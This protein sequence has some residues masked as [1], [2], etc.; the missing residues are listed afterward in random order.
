MKH[1]NR[2]RVTA[3]FFGGFA[4]QLSGFKASNMGRYTLAFLLTGLMSGHVLADEPPCLQLDDMS[5]LT[6]SLRESTQPKSCEN[7]ALISQPTAITTASS[8]AYTASLSASPDI[9]AST[10]SS[11]LDVT[12]PNTVWQVDVESKVATLGRD[13][14]GDSIDEASGNLSFRHVDVSLPGNSHLPVEFARTYRIDGIDYSGNILGGW[15]PDVPFITVRLDGAIGWVA[16]GGSGTDSHCFAN[17][18]VRMSGASNPDAHKKLAGGL[19]MSI[20]GQGMQPLVRPSN[21]TVNH[22]YYV[23]LPRIDAKTGTT[24]DNWKVICEGDIS[25]AP[26]Q[27]MTA[28]APN[29]DKYIFDVFVKRYAGMETHTTS[30]TRGGG[31]EQLEVNQAFHY[32]L[33]ASKIIDVSGNEVSY[34]YDGGG[35]LTKISANDGR[36]ID[37]SYKG[38]LFTEVPNSSTDLFSVD[39]ES[40][41]KSISSVTTNGRTWTYHYAT[42]DDDNYHTSVQLNLRSVTLPNGK[43]WTFN[44]PLQNNRATEYYNSY[45]C[46][47]ADKPDVDGYTGSWL[48]RLPSE[49]FVRHP[50]GAKINFEFDLIKNAGGLKN[51]LSGPETGL[52]DNLFEPLR[53]CERQFSNMTI[54]RAVTEKKVSPING[55]S[56]SWQYEYDESNHCRPASV[57]AKPTKARTIIGPDG[58]KTVKHFYCDNPEN[59][60]LARQEVYEGE[61]LLEVS[62][63]EYTTETYLNEFG[64]GPEHFEQHRTMLSKQTIT[65]GSDTYNKSIMYNTD[66]TSPNYSYGMPTQLNE[67]SSVQSDERIFKYSYQHDRTNW[68]LQKLNEVQQN[69]A[70]INSVTLD[71]LGRTS[72]HYRYG[73]LV[74]RYTYKTEPSSEKGALDQYFDG[75]DRGTSFSDYNAGRPQKIT[76]P[77][78]ESSYQY[79]D[80]NGWTTKKIDFND[81]C[82]NYSYNSIGWL[83]QINHCDER[84]SDTNIDYTTT[85]SDDDT[86]YVNAGML[87]QTM[88]TGN[89][90]RVIYHDGF[91]RPALVKEWDTNQTS[92]AR[93]LR[94]GYDVLGRNTYQ[95]F[96][97]SSAS[98]PYG[99]NTEYDGLSRVKTTTNNTLTGNTHYTYLNNN[100]VQVND[101]NGHVTTTS[102]LAY[103][104]PNQNQATLIASPHGVNTTTAYDIYG[105]VKSITQ[106]GIAEYRVYND[107]QQL[108]KTV[109]PD[110]GNTALSYNIIGEVEWKASGSSVSSSISAC[111]DEV[112][113]AHKISYV[114]DVLGNMK[115]AN[116]AD[117][118][119]DVSYS[120]D[121]NNNLKTL[122]SC[123]VSHTYNY[124][125]LNL[126]KDETL[127]LPGK[128]L[129]IDYGYNALGSLSSLTYPDDDVITYSPNG[130]G[131]PTQAIRNARVADEP[132]TDRTYASG[133]KY[134]PAGSINTFAYG[135]GLT[136]KTTLNTRNV[137]SIIKDSKTGLTAL[138]YEYEYDDNLNITKLLDKVDPSY[139][140]GSATTA[141][142]FYDGLDRLTSTLGGAG[143]GNSAIG[144]DVLGNITSY[145]SKERNLTYNYNTTANRLTS[146]SGY[147]SQPGEASTKYDS[148]SYDDRG[149][150]YSNGDKTFTYNRANQLTTSGTNSYLYDGHNRRV[151]QTDAKGTSYSLYSQSG[152]LLYRETDDG[153]INYIYLGKKLIAKDGVI[154]ENSGKQHYRPFGESIEGAKDDVGYTGHKFDAD[155]GLSY[156]QA[157]YY[158]PVIGRFYSNDPVGY[159]SR[160]PVHS[161]GRYTYANNNPYRY[162]DPD[163]REGVGQRLDLRVE[164]LGSGEITREQFSSENMAEGVGGLVAAPIAAAT[165]ACGASGACASAV[166]AAIVTQ[167]AKPKLGSKGGPG[168]GKNFS[169]KTKDAARTESGNTCVFCGKTTIRSKT[170]HPDRSNIDHAKSK[171]NGGNNT[172][173]NAQ[174]TCQ[175]CNLDKGAL[176]TSEYL[177]SRSN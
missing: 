72:H 155:L 2:S 144:Y 93:Y 13:F 70:I 134:H 115:K 136:H 106:G 74:G 101:N 149:N 167:V 28:T 34:S 96:A 161:F 52:T 146:V 42:P 58:I 125:S 88:T 121:K 173:D 7:T 44:L 6:Q 151:K 17:A 40:T 3:L 110:V 22:P 98:T 25:N 86:P 172:L 100:R 61:D 114:Y 43:K 76:R 152:T 57:N 162:T 104:V 148:F 177:K 51:H 145:T 117:T 165:M 107:Y 1:L 168:A 97:H 37:I 123:T 12:L 41:Y 68:I 153:G 18:V 65:R 128:I 64:P 109:R 69:D 166:T 8:S 45:V 124:N 62:D 119:P 120:Y 126:L 92:I 78:G 154:P 71:N 176:D 47:G 130:L 54:A 49:S 108:C 73:R 66:L 16:D 91:Y 48:N 99:I 26:G 4:S 39:W 171:K 19:R 122:T 38:S 139:S 31:G 56:Y 50:E 80:D 142:L 131:Q 112:T 113:A 27:A 140:L 83:T 81:N 79:V 53:M 164:R 163:G 87:K 135:N 21:Y 15:L 157:R 116:F 118:S 94:S 160:N 170:S 84:W 169:E 95:S 75:L 102:Y 55:A 85:P 174:N 147:V 20:P 158:D 35:Y 111:D 29:G 23:E 11:N 82:T 89:H 105:K 159:V 103:G 132:L 30:D 150:I 129:S 36:T 90:K 32:I 77:D 46:W 24:K 60:Q 127:T 59:G 156:M 10:S 5:V 14:V 138:H 9:S 141:G 137:P 33:Y 63:Y 133:A 175:T 67:G 143:I